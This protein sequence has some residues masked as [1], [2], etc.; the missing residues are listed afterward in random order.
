VAL[1]FSA[2]IK[3]W[4][5][6]SPASSPLFDQYIAPWSG[7]DAAVAIA[8]P[9]GIDIPGDWFIILPIHRQQ[10]AAERLNQL[11]DHTGILKDYQYNAFQIRQLL[12][13]SFFPILPD[14]WIPNPF[15]T[16]INDFAIFASSQAALEVWLDAYISG[17]T[18]ANNEAFLAL[19]ANTPKPGNWQFY[20]AA[21]KM[22]VQL[23]S[24]APNDT[25]LP[26]I[27]NLLGNL[28]IHGQP[29][30]NGWRFSGLFNRQF[31]TPIHSDIAWKTLLSAPALSPPFPIHM[32]AANETCIAI[33][34]Q[35]F[36][37]YLIGP[38]GDIRWSRLVD[39]PII[40]NIQV[41]DDN[42]NI[43]F[44][45]SHNIYVVNSQGQDIG[46]FPLPLQS[47]ATNGLSVV[48]FDGGNQIGFFIACNNGNAYGFDRQG[49]PLPGWNPLPDIGIVKLPIIHFA[50]DNKDYLIT[51]NDRQVLQLFARDGSLRFP[52]KALE[53]PFLSIPKFQLSASSNRIVAINSSGKAHII[54]LNNEHFNLLC[55]VGL[56]KQVKFEFADVSGDDRKEYIVISEQ[57]LAV[58]GY[59]A[60]N[61]FINILNFAANDP[62]Q[63]VFA[64]AL[65]NYPKSLIGA[66]SQKSGKIFLL[67]DKGELLPGFPLAGHHPFF[68]ADLY[69]N[70]QQLAISA[71]SDSVYAFIIQ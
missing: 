55:P 54:G 38:S 13:P 48:N 39:G 56:N 14:E 59:N 23:K 10:L 27:A 65:P 64:I 31:H 41:L 58:Y 6:F 40:S 21:E 66:V 8:P 60:K 42:A 28:M 2:S 5:N 68:V 33:Q 26:T 20:L 34:D 24:A 1:L 19:N 63:D 43:I 11:A 45:T 29:Y 37:V 53:G 49:R 47:P 22:N 9:R 52:P 12:T 51:L 36:R 17:K 61:Q 16:T 46:N 25:R 70:G 62:L 57:Q 69:R 32:P 18:L 15:F 35:Q 3:N 50:K 67:N 30:R 7:R 4:R 71:Y 44:N